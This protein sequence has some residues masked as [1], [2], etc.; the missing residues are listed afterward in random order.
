MQYYKCKVQCSNEKFS[1]EFL[2][3]QFSV[4]SY[5]P[6]MENYFDEND[7]IDLT[8]NDSE[9]TLD[10]SEEEE[11]HPGGEVD[12]RHQFKTN[13]AVKVSIFVLHGGGPTGF[14]T[15]F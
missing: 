15:K 2:E 12:A 4:F 9:F 14:N 5:F 3:E 8:D 1:V 6:N 13:S 7:I 10:T 11:D